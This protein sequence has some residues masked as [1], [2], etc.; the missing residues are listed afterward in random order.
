MAK[1]QLKPF[2]IIH[3]IEKLTDEERAAYL[4]K[5]SEFMGLPPEMNALDMLWVSDEETGLKKYVPYARKGTTDILRE[6]HGIKVLSMEQHDGPSYVSFKATG[7]NP[8][9]RQEVA[10]GAHGTDGLRGE[11]LAAAVMTAETRAGR[12]LTL[13]FVGAG[14]LDE[15]EV[16]AVTG[17]IA[18]S[19][20][21]LA[22]LAGSPVVVPPMPGA[23]SAATGRDITEKPSQIEKPKVDLTIHDLTPKEATKIETAAEKWMRENPTASDFRMPTPEEIADMFAKEQQALRDEAARQ[24]QEKADKKVDTVDTGVPPSGAPSTTSEKPEVAKKLA[25]RGRPRKKAGT[26]TFED[27]AASAARVADG[28][29]LPA[30]TADA[31]A[32]CLT[33]GIPLTNHDYAEGGGGYVCRPADLAKISPLPEAASA[34]VP[35]TGEAQPETPAA[36]KVSEPPATVSREGGTVGTGQERL[37]PLAEPVKTEYHVPLPPHV[38]LN[39]VVIPDPSIPP[40]ANIAVSVQANPALPTQSPLADIPKSQQ[41]ATSA[42]AAIEPTKLKEF[43]DRLRQY[44]NVILPKQGGMLPSE[45]IGGAPNKLRAFALKFTGGAEVEKLTLAQWESLFDFLDSNQNDP[46]GLVNY[47][48]EAIGAK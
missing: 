39:V 40:Q 2:T 9:G 22:Q 8:D 34:V 41:P 18:A 45:G 35:A 38:G 5:V 43:R 6:I 31:P 21:S 33:C 3:N 27:A 11:K 1:K 46:K 14:I 48:N 12:R 30:R 28:P 20:A 26:V 17:N 10:V 4:A 37:P 44:S 7:V 42:A 16:G 25:K 47:I 19:G 15:S 24:L 13:K 23:P 29:T 32:L 36:L